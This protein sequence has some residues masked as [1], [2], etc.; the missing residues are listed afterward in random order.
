MNTLDRAS[1]DLDSRHTLVHSWHEGSIVE[2]D[3]VPRG[4]TFLFNDAIAIQ[5]LSGELAVKNACA[6]VNCKKVE[7]AQE[8]AKTCTQ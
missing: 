5:N 7:K 3:M 6:A 1:C 2:W 8:S 4:N